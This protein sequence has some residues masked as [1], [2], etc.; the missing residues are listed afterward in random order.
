MPTIATDPGCTAAMWLGVV[1]LS[2]VW[3]L[4]R[5]LLYWGVRE[6][7]K[8]AAVML[9]EVKRLQNARWMDGTAEVEKTLDEVR[10]MDADA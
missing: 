1:V 4:G 7:T 10:R 6:E 5:L 9:A 3:I 8:R 2:V